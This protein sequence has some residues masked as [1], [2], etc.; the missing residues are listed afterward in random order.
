MQTSP[1]KD[2]V[3]RP[4]HGAPSANASRW[5]HI[6]AFRRQV[7]P[8]F[9]AH[10]KKLYR[11]AEFLLHLAS[12][13]NVVPSAE[14]TLVNFDVLRARRGRLLFLFGACVTVLC[15]FGIW[16]VLFLVFVFICARVFCFMGRLIR[17]W[18]HLIRFRGCLI[19]FWGRS[20]LLR[21][22]SFSAFGM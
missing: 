18:G 3:T 2:N 15:F 12:G 5:Q 11:A 13:A 19:R 8:P 1:C 14:Q 7:I 4:V 9:R 6:T 10:H 20:L 22:C 21:V 16:A 17:L